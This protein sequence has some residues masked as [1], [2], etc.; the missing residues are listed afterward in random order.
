M[1]KYFPTQGDFISY[2]FT[3]QVGH[4]Q[5]GKRPALVVSNDLFNS[6]S[7][8]LFVCPVTNN[9]REYPFHV[10]IPTGQRV[11]GVIMV[12]QMKAIDHEDRRVSF[13]GKAP[14]DLLEETLSM[15]RSILQ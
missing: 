8:V 14:N 9:N 5:Q 11:S 2:F 13:L 3:N 7:H 12:D 6:N 4:E 1:A 15:L 10:P